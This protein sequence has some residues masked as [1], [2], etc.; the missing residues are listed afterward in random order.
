M[1]IIMHIC[2]TA[3]YELTDN[4]YG[5]TNNA[6]QQYY[7]IAA[8][9]EVKITCSS[10]DRYLMIFEHFHSMLNIVYNLF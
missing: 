9:L 3:I 1:R 6:L 8:R 2:H 7:N 10:H 5:F 4:Y